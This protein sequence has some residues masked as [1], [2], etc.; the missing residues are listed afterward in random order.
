[1]VAAYYTFHFESFLFEM[2]EVMFDMVVGFYDFRSVTDFPATMVITYTDFLHR[3][4]EN[5]QFG[6]LCF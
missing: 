5:Q 1:M 4:F 2:L 6:I 3:Y